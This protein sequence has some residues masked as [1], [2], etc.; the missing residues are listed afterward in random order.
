MADEVA[1]SP[2]KGLVAESGNPAVDPERVAVLEGELADCRSQLEN[3]CQARN[4]AVAQNVH[5]VRQLS[6]ASTAREELSGVLE[7]ALECQHN[8]EG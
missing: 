6:Q 1:A 7:Q 8:L 3:A 5:F 2:S 4:E